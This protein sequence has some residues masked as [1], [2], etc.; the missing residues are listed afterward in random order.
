MLLRPTGSR[1]AE[2]WGKGEGARARAHTFHSPSMNSVSMSFTP[3]E[4]GIG[5]Q[6]RLG[7]CDTGGRL[8]GEVV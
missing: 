4:R 1:T 7:A 8:A 2:G 3:A 5:H 6:P